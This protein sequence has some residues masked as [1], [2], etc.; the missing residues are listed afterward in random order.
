MD[1][2]RV[3]QAHAHDQDLV[4][5]VMT[6]WRRV[7]ARLGFG[8]VEGGVL[9]AEWVAQMAAI[10]LGVTPS[11]VQPAATAASAASGSSAPRR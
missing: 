8:E 6:M 1:S 5:E 4:A 2:M 7:I 10:S 9:H 3:V 11:S